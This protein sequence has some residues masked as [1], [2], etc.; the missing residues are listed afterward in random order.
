MV[1]RDNTFRISAMGG[2]PGIHV[3]CVSPSPS[4]NECSVLH[5]RQYSY[6]NIF[7]ISFN[8]WQ[9]KHCVTLKLRYCGSGCAPP[10]YRFFLSR[11][12]AQFGEKN[13]LFEC[14]SLTSIFPAAHMLWRILFIWR[15]RIILLF[16]E[17]TIGVFAYWHETKMNRE[18]RTRVCDAIAKHIYKET[19][20]PPKTALG[21]KYP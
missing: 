4:G 11:K 15:Y 9:E 20:R 1:S 6:S 14:F 12:K 7:Q 8:I 17:L 19:D 2:Q 18:R 5:K 10:S 16:L 13:I 21:I 3:T